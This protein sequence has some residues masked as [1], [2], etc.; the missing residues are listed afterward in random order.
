M[1]KYQVLEKSFINNQI[2]EEGE[3]LDDYDGLP[4]ENLKPLDEAGEIKA[5]EYRDSNA[6]RLATQTPAATPL[7]NAEVFAKAFAAEMQK[8]GLLKTTEPAAESHV[9]SPSMAKAAKKAAAP[10]PAPA[11]DDM[12]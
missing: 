10:A 7:D 12:A 2:R 8:L 6:K 9:V 1:P 4:S 11:A 3:I 5:Q